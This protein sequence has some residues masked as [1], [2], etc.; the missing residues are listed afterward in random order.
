MAI[1]REALWRSVGVG[2]EI[3]EE[4]E[5]SRDEFAPARRFDKLPSRVAVALAVRSLSLPP[6]DVVPL[7]STQL[8]TFACARHHAR[9]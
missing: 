7:R 1:I 5:T 6:R 8:R 9:R 2:R 3:A 4:R